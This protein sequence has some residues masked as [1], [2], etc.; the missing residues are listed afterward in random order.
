MA[1]NT[2]VYF[3]GGFPE[4]IVTIVKK[5]GIRDALLETNNVVIG[6]SAGAMLWSHKFFVWKDGDYDKYK[7]FKGL[8]VIKDF[9]IVPHFVASINSIH[10]NRACRRFKRM[11]PRKTIYLMQDGGYIIYDK[12]TQQIIN[13]HMTLIY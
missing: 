13:K 4:N 7:S 10:V 3:P 5:L 1:P 12:Q 8:K 11:N 2:L 6:A 9:C